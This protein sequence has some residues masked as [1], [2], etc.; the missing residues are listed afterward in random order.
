MYKPVYL[1]IGLRYLWN[2]H[3]PKFK[4]FITLLSIIGI[5]ISTASLI[6]V[7]SVINGFEEN[8]KKNILSFIPHL[9]ITNK[10]KC[11]NKSEFPKNIVNLYNFEKV[12]DFINQE[13]I[14]RSKN[15]ITIGEIIGI[16]NTNNE[17]ITNYN[18]KNVLNTLQPKQKNAIL[19]IEL[20]KKLHVHIGDKIKL[21]LLPDK[22]FFF[23]EIFNEKTFK[24]VD[25]FSTN[26]EIDYYQ[27]LINKEDSLEFLHFP[28]NFITGWRVWFKQ[29][30]SLNL[31]QIK[32]SLNNFV[33]L[34]W[35]SQKGEIF[36][37]MTIEKYII[38]LLFILI[39]IVAILNIFITLTV[40]TIE[41][42][43]SIAIL[44]TQGLANWKIILIFIIIGSSTAI[45]GNILGT[46]ISVLLIMQNDFL[47][48]LI[49]IFFD[50]IDISIIIVPHQIFFINII[51]I[52]ITSISTL[53]PAYNAIKLKPA[54]ILSHE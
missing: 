20:A 35:K 23:K 24:I 36:K 27:I 41:K 4:K 42:K 48:F 12:S 14:L 51:S 7:I 54:K 21:I 50:E 53:Y 19:G 13:V 28:K 3:L 44:Q 5:I 17:N 47:K 22:K 8:F 33:L 1:F 15:D 2:S 9:I 38:L 39:L 10:N 30:L 52:F 45:I 32:K 25:F 18:L 6:I 49:K 43:S 11:I 26:N 16:D 29:P 40:Y 37:A 34:D 46:V 31:D